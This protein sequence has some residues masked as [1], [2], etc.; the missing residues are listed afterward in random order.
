MMVCLKKERAHLIE[1]VQWSF[2]YLGII[3]VVTV[4]LS[5]DDV[6]M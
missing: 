5:L 4:T 1:A 6:V 3:T 2:T